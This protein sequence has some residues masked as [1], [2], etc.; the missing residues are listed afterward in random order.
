M[1]N[2]RSFFQ[3]YFFKYAFT[4]FLNSNCTYFK[5]HKIVLLVSETQSIFFPLHSSYPST[6][7]LYSCGF[8][9]YVFKFTDI[10]FCSMWPALLPWMFY[11]SVLNEMFS[12][13]IF[14]SNFIIFIFYLKPLNMLMRVILKSLSANSIISAFSGSLSIHLIF[15]W[16]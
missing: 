8:F 10:F 13:F 11:F 2:S 4:P 3:H 5:S 7:K 15:T 6:P 14:I 1:E 16:W 12:S 9:C